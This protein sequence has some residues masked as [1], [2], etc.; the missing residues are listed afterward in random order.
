MLKKALIAIA[1]IIAVFITAL[2]VFYF[3]LMRPAF[4]EINAIQDMEIGEVDLSL[5]ADGAYQGDFAY[6]KFTCEVEVFVKDHKIEG[7]T[8]IQN[9]DTKYAKMSEGVLVKIVEKQSPN[10]DAITGATTTSKAFMKAVENALNKGI[11]K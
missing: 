8:A 3:T 1:I 2:V 11:R 4:K 6:G 10:V 9:R 5:V 7:I